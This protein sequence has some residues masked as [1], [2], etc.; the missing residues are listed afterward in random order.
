MTENTPEIV[1]KQLSVQLSVRTV[2]SLSF[3][4][5][6]LDIPSAM[7]LLAMASSDEITQ[8]DVPA[9]MEIVG[10]MVEG[11]LSGVPVSQMPRL[12]PRVLS[13]LGEAMNPKA[14]S[15]DSETG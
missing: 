14:A 2:D 7:R 13:V 8:A 9:F 11:G 6:A 10:Q 15:G 12:I 1:T 4:P 5:D 3:N